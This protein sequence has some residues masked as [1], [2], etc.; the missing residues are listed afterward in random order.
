ML[1]V[2]KVALPGREVTTLGKMFKLL[3]VVAVLF[4]CGGLVSGHFHTAR[5]L[6][7][8]GKYPFDEQKVQFCSYPC[9]PKVLRLLK[10][11]LCPLRVSGLLWYHP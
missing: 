3:C 4:W 2:Q 8:F 10:L 7:S 1:R 11:I 5:C 9:R 6:P